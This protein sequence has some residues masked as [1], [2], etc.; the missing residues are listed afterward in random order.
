MRALAKKAFRR[1]LKEN[2]EAQSLLRSAGSHGQTEAI[3]PCKPG[4]PGPSE[5]G[6]RPILNPP[7]L[8]ILVSTTIELH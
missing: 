7:D 1:R 8:E 4:D 6:D 5:K 2:H 3:I